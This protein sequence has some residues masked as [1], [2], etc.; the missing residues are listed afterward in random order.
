MKQLV[1][2]VQNF[3]SYA[4]DTTHWPLLGNEQT[5]DP[6][7]Q[8]TPMPWAVTARNLVLYSG[9]STRAGDVTATVQKNI[10]DTALAA[11]VLAS[12]NGPITVGGIDVSF[13]Q[14]DDCRFEFTDTGGAALIPGYVFGWC[15]ELESQGNVFGIPANLFG[16]TAVGDGGIGGAL[17]NGFWQTYSPA[18]FSNPLTRSTTYSICST[19]GSLTRLVLRTYSTP[20]PVGSSWVGYYRLNGVI[21]D[22][23]GGTVNTKCEIVGNGSLDRATASFTLPI[24]PR[25]H[26]EVLYYRTGTDAV[27]ELA[28]KIGVGIGFIPTKAGYF[29]LTGGSNQALIAPGYVWPLSV[30]FETDELKAQAPVGPGGF[31][32][33]GLYI[34]APE[35]GVNPADEVTRWLRKSGVNTLIAVV[36]QHLQTSGSI[37]GTNV[38][39][40]QDDFVTISQVP[41]GGSPDASELYWGLEMAPDSDVGIIG[42]LAWIHWPRTLP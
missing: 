4:D 18:A 19:P 36:L 20:P 6:A 39:F 7:M 42:P 30:A 11:T 21:Q 22:G 34:E 28:G 5:Y 38:R 32:A 9:D 29:M 41:T 2:H 37:T 40:N 16:F 23:T 15:I 8:R 35:P 14:Y 31:I 13:S 12:E 1:L 24:V 27:F 10:V 3:V 17:G 33:R 25:D 26:V